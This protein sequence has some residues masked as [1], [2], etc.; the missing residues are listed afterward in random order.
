M[1]M[2][3]KDRNAD[4][5]SFF[6]EKANGYDAVISSSALHHFTSD[7]KRRLY[8]KVFDA[9]S[10]GGCFISADCIY[11]TYEEEKWVFDNYDQLVTEWR[12]VDTPLAESTERMLLDEAGFVDIAFTQLENPLYKLLFAMKK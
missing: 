11:S 7:D 8:K 9:L 3:L 2:N 5:R 6:N 1:K 4:M 10:P 12:H